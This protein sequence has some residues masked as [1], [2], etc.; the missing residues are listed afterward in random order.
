MVVEVHGEDDVEAEVEVEVK[1]EV[2]VEDEVEMDV[3]VAVE[4]A[5]PTRVSVV[6]TPT[7]SSVEG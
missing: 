3:E 4:D 2:E 6:N 5:H 7:H 1:V